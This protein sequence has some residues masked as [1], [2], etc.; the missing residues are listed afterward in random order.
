MAGAASIDLKMGESGLL[1]WAR[2]EQLSLSFY[3]A[4]TLQTAPGCFSGSEFVKTVTGVDNVCE[5]AA[6]L[7]AG[8]GRLICSKQAFGGVTVAAAEKEMRIVL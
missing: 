1:E 7:A 6:V 4:E 2:G 8:G 5:R 3:S